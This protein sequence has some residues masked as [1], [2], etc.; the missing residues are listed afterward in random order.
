[1]I[2]LVAP[3]RRSKCARSA[4]ARQDN[5]HDVIPCTLFPLRRIAPP[6]R[7]PMP[8][9][10]CAAMRSSIPSACAIWIETIVNSAEARDRR[11]TWEEFWGFEDLRI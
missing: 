1:M 4:A 7:N 10:I 5:E 2:R 3:A 6:P 9:T 11:R 8:V